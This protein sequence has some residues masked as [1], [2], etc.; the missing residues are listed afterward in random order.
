MEIEGQPSSL[1]DTFTSKF[2]EQ[3]QI[4]VEQHGNLIGKLLRRLTSN[5]VLISEHWLRLHSSLIIIDNRAFFGRVL[6]VIMT[7]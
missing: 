5:S 1:V 6:P 3:S 4:E 2:P 7:L